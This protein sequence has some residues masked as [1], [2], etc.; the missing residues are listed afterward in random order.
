M[1]SCVSQSNSQI[2]LQQDLRYNC[3]IVDPL[4]ETL[5]ERFINLDTG[6]I[7]LEIL[8]PT[9]MILNLVAEPQTLVG[10]LKG[11]IIEQVGDI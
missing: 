9:G 7:T 6:E 1:Y 5:P 8:L 3:F 2:Y 10:T 11:F 4:L